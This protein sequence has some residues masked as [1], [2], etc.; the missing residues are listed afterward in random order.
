MKK[1]IFVLLILFF[2]P[3]VCIAHGYGDFDLLGNV[4]AFKGEGPV[5]EAPALLGGFSGALVGLPVGVL[6]GVIVSPIGYISSGFE[7]A[8]FGALPVFGGFLGIRGGGLLGQYI[9]GSPFWLGKKIL[10]DTPKSLLEFE[11]AF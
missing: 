7:P 5:V 11:Y 10:W 3:S 4:E 1:F 6:S 9:L 8:A 2:I